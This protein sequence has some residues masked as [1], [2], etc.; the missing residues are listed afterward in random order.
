VRPGAAEPGD[1]V[2]YAAAAALSSEVDSHRPGNGHHR[3]KMETAALAR[4]ATRHRVPSVAMRAVADGAGDQLG[5]R[6]FPGQFSTTIAWRPENAAARSPAPAPRMP[7]SRA[8]RRRRAAGRLRSRSRP[9]RPLDPCR[10]EVY[11]Q[12]LLP[13]RILMFTQF[14]PTSPPDLF[15]SPSWTMNSSR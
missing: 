3:Q 6:G 2:A 10:R 8:S 5:S 11:G 13:V 4:V 12:L 15:W 7:S 1:R 14:S 9:A